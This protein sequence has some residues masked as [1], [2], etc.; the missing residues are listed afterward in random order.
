VPRPSLTLA[1]RSKRPTPLIPLAVPRWAHPK[2]S[3]Q[4]FELA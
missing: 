1:D 2:R 3:P 4:F